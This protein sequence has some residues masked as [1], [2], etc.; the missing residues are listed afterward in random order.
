MNKCVK[1]IICLI[2]CCFK[3]FKC[4]NKKEQ[5]RYAVS[6]LYYLVKFD[7]EVLFNS[8]ISNNR[9]KAI[10]VPDGYCRP[11]ST[12]YLFL[13]MFN[14]LYNDGLM[15]LDIMDSPNHREAQKALH[16]QMLERMDEELPE[17]H[18]P[19]FTNTREFYQRL[20]KFLKENVSSF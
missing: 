18:V 1:I 16:L 17:L 13:D 6:S 8:K 9:E 15:L 4:T 11:F 7:Q 5:L 10:Y 19:E 14:L 12:P 3:I 2:S 20:E